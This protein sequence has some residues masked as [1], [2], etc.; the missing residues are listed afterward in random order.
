MRLK[1]N[2]HTNGANLLVYWRLNHLNENIDVNETT[3][4]SETT[5]VYESL[6]SWSD[7]SSISEQAYMA[8]T[9]ESALPQDIGNPADIKN[10]GVDSGATSHFTPYLEDLID[11]EPCAVG[12]TIADGSEVIGTHKGK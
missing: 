8:T 2:F 1:D 9:N 10:W 12:V 3:S 6:S 4:D 5:D 11:A 7:D